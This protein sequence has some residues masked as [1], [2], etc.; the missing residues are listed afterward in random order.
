[1]LEVDVERTHLLQVS[2]Y[3]QSDCDVFFLQL[4][5]VL[6]VL[7]PAAV[8][9][10]MFQPLDCADIYNDGNGRSGVYRIFPEGPNSGRYVYCDMDTDGGKWTVFQRRMDGTV[11]FY[12]GWQEYKNGFGHAAG[13]YWLGL[14]TIHLLN[15]K[16]KYELRVD[17]EDF[18]GATVSASYD[19]F[20]IS[21]DAL[22]GEEDGYTLHISGFRNGGAGDSLSHHNGQ[23]F[24]TFDKDQD[25]STENCA[26]IRLGGFWY[27]DCIRTNPNGV[28]MQGADDVK[29]ACWY[30]WKESHLSL[31]SIS[32]KIRPVSL[33]DV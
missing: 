17:M 2:I 13:E 23:K 25:V 12:R 30:D 3:Q 4:F 33:S 10:L 6:A 21:P 5:L 7:L 1:M 26:L 15:L 8:N 31:K 28:Y 9:S 24:S 18:N 22:N 20:A 29:S 19:S 16:K 32:M 14:E 27:F 11:N